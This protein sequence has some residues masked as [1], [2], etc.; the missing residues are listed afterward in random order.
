MTSWGFS[1][2]EKWQKRLFNR[3]SAEMRE[4]VDAEASPRSTTQG[5]TR[6]AFRNHVAQLLLTLYKTIYSGPVLY[7]TSQ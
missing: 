2:L 6:R 5:G 4:E 7:W 3:G 1:L